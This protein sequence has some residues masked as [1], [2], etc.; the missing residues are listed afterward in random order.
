MIKT[1]TRCSGEL[2]FIEKT[3]CWRCLS[4]YPEGQ[5]KPVEKPPKKEDPDVVIMKKR[6]RDVIAEVVPDMIREELENWVSP[7][8]ATGD[9]IEVS[10]D[11]VYIPELDKHKN[12]RSE[13]KE[14]GIEVYDR[15]KKKLRLKVD[16]IA[17]IDEKLNVIKGET[18]VPEELRTEEQAGS[19]GSE[20][21]SV[22]TRNAE[23]AHG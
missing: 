20:R 5:N 21:S 13:A 15:E 14:L 6:I 4:C 11:E 23:A 16:V 1:C 19:G 17:D 7:T 2:T 3:K 22:D 18:S 12:W 8:A 10:Q 9:S